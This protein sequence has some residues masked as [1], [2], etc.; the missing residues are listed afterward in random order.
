MNNIET[1]V[2]TGYYDYDGFY[3]GEH[4]DKGD[5]FISIGQSVRIKKKECNKIAKFL[6]RIHM[7]G[8]NQVSFENGEIHE[9]HK[10]NNYKCINCK[11]KKNRYNLNSSPGLN[12]CSRCV[13]E[14]CNILR[15]FSNTDINVKEF[16]NFYVTK[17][18]NPVDQTKKCLITG[19]CIEENEYYV[20][21]GPHIIK[22]CNV[23][24]IINEAY[25]GRLYKNI[26]EKCI[27]C[28]ES[29]HKT[30]VSV[31]YDAQSFDKKLYSH[32]LCFN[33]VMINL[34]NISDKMNNE[35]ITQKI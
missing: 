11:I 25:E 8:F 4:P 21:I 33:D 17:Y 13:K 18:K 31:Y 20:Q 24:N 35:I 9:I 5:I 16:G 28:T 23:G 26:S 22:L 14:L 27:H 32:P 30:A 1:G 12:L 6:E 2:Y 7:R 29:I 15:D 3:L 10:S 19:D 34:K